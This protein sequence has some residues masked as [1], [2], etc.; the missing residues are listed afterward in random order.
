MDLP[1]DYR[2]LDW[3]LGEVRE[4]REEYIKR[5]DGKCAY[6]GGQLSEGPPARIKI[7][8]I[9]WNLFPEKFTKYPVHLHHCHH[10]GMT[11]GAVH[12]RCNAVLFQYEGR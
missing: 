5:Q 10:T 2:T 4:V 7:K 3:R 6:C 11:E 12:M 9:N 1:V 8:K